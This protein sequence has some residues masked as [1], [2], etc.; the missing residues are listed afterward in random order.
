MGPRKL[1]A[2]ALLS[3]SVLLGAI[4]GHATCSDS[5]GC[6]GPGLGSDGL[7]NT[8]VGGPSGNIVSYRFRAGHTGSLQQI[9]VYLIPNHT[10]YSAGTGGSLKVTV[11]TD[12]GTA[13]HNPSSSVLASYLL[14]NP[15]AATPSIN[16]PIFVFTAPPSLVEGQLYH[17]VFANVDPNPT[18]NY[19][20]VD[21]LYYANP[22]TPSQPTISDLD[23]AELLGGPG[24]TWAPRKGYTPI[25][26]LDYEDGYKELNGYMEVWVGAPQNISGSAEIRQTM[27]VSGD[28]KSVSSVSIR[29]ARVS[30]SDPL[31]VT[32]LNSSGTVIEQGEI[33]ATS[34]PLTSPAS[35]A[36]ATYTFS[37][38]HTLALGQS[39]YL[40]FSAAS[41]STYEAF[42][43]RKGMAYGFSSATYFPDGYAQFSSSGSWMG[44]TQWGVT[45]RTD[46][47]LQFYFGLA[48]GAS[49]APTISDVAAG[50]LTSSGVTI[51]WATD[52]PST[53]QVEYGISTA[54]GNITSLDT[55][56]VTAHSEALSQL[57]ASALY[58]YRVHSTNAAGSEATSGDLTFTTAAQAPVAPVISNIV[59]GSISSSGATI[60]WTT[61]QP[62][63]S[64]VEYGT[65]TGYGYSTPLNASDV[66]A[67]SQLLASLAGSTLYHY[68]VHSTN[69]SGSSSVSADTTFKTAAPAVVA[70]VISNVAAGSITFTSA[71]ISWTTNQAATTQIQYGTTTAYGHWSAL[72]STFSSSHSQMLTG[73]SGGHAYHYRVISTNASGVRAVSGD[74][75]FTTS[76]GSRGF[77][78]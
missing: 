76:S 6:Y 26:Q 27:T 66:T 70:P 14:S 75:S 12:D 53:S 51:T 41:S 74:F 59:A 20:S 40:Q 62:S 44:W 22:T 71:A 2:L 31:T 29:A 39:Y 63:S 30:G 57:I 23:S 16:F 67:H 15:L 10:G 43:I 21:A 77:R 24:G 28:S 32:L 50:S 42:P 11:N 7:A 37:S 38:A 47:D 52:Q 1:H 3:I 9:H 5:L 35:Y 64:Q 36:W 68:R 61:D 60:A 72:N 48:S 55:A 69:A 73:L 18:A 58:H 78:R 65:T 45:N 25:L 54:Y 13:A 56:D 33:P 4:P 17:I 34:F 8:V 46:G 19:I 49:A